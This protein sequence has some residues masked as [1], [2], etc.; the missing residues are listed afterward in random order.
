MKLKLDFNS[1]VVLI[2]SLLAAMVYL[3]NDMTDNAL[4]PLFSLSA[5][6]NSANPLEYLTLLTYILGHANAEHLMGNLMLILLLGP[7][8]EEKYG[9]KKLLIMIIF[10]ALLTGILN[11]MLFTTG[12]MGASGIVFMFIILVSFVNVKRG[13]IPITFL[14]IVVLYVGQEILQVFREDN[15][16]QFGH[17]A[18]GFFGGLF[19]FSKLMQPRQNSPER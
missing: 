12:I 2:F 7:V 9:S 13:R 3:F 16:S 18:G 10:T 19:G 4:T 11:L 5:N 8:L 15:I 14:L 17:I 1:P 6:F